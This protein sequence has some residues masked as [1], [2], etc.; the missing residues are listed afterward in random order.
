MEHLVEQALVAAPHKRL[1]WQLG[2]VVRVVPET[3][4]TK[5]LVLEVP[6]WPQHQ[7]GQHLDV[8]LTAEDGYQAQRSYSVGSPP[9]D[10]HVAITVERLEDGEVSPYLTDELD[11]GDELELRG[12]IGGY[13]TWQASQ[14]GPLLLVAGGSGVVP[15]MAMIR[16]RAA[17]G[18]E[19]P[20]RLL[21]S[22]R[23]F[24][25]II[26]REELDQLAQDPGLEV[27]H[28]LTRS[29]PEG[30]AGHR[31]RIDSTLL[32]EVAW[33]SQQ[34]PHIFICGPTRLVEAVATTLTEL[35]HDPARVKT[36]RFGP[37]GG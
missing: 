24:E 25:D 4:R 28:T 20:A 11:I 29:Q 26:Y 36:E 10:K 32:E 30:W 17:A 23:T 1:V 21:Y 31:R 37:S 13:F 5:T 34:Q 33:P 2:K 27:F 19:V 16:H 7:P 9:E 35:G 22:S 3:S 8:R 14:G 6:D 18:R 15:L 12:P